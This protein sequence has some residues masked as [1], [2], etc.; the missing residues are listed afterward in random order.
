MNPSL[1]SKNQAQGRAPCNGLT[2][3]YVHFYKLS[4]IIC[5]EAN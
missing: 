3:L 5:F 1:L 4:M 2:M